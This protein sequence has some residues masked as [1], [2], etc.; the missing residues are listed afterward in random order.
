MTRTDGT[1]AEF[2]AVD[3]ADKL[4]GSISLTKQVTGPGAGSLPA[5]TTFTV[6]YTYEGLGL[7]GPGT[8]TL[9]NGQTVS[10]SGVPAGN[11]VTLTEVAPTGGISSAFAWVAPV[12][13]LPDG[14]RSPAPATFAVTKAGQALSIELDNPTVPVIPDTGLNAPQLTT[15]GLTLIFLGGL[16]L[17]LGSRRRSTYRS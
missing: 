8:V 15:T 3:V 17:V 12:F 6:D 10:V 11:R 5:G 2:A 7:K 16:L 9:V 14:T 1:T 13:V 4:T